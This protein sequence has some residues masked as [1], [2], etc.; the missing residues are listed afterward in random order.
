MLAGQPKFRNFH[1]VHTHAHYYSSIS[2]YPS[3]S[4]EL[5][6]RTNSPI[7]F[8][9]P[10]SFSSLAILIL[11]AM[12]ILHFFIPF[13]CYSPYIHPHIYTFTFINLSL[14]SIFAIILLCSHNFKCAIFLFV[15]LH[16]LSCSNNKSSKYLQT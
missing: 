5:F 3:L 7:P 6:S 12:H 16:H 11:V 1:A 15:L 8:S 10:R 4:N 14:V 13:L 2:P 9:Y